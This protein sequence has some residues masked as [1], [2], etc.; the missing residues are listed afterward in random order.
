MR[1]LKFLSK[2]EGQSKH[3]KQQ[4]LYD[5]IG[6]KR[7][8]IVSNRLP[9]VIDHEDDEWTI[10]P[11]TGGL[12]TALAPIIKENRGVVGNFQFIKLV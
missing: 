4:N 6:S 12:I 10:R 1:Q 7:L 3:K 5:L 8:L 2:G 9:V 11:G